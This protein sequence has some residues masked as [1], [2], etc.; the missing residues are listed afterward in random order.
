MQTRMN[1]PLLNGDLNKDPNIKARKQRG[2]LLIRG[3]R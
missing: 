2:G 3:L 1:N